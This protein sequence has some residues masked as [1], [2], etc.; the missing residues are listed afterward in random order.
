MIKF[1]GI[2]AATAMLC[3]C[4]VQA[5]GPS[6]SPPQRLSADA[7]SAGPHHP[8]R[9]VYVAG[10]SSVAGYSF[11]NASNKPPVCTVDLAN[12][13]S[14]LEDVAVDRLG[15]LMVPANDD[16]NS[17]EI[18]SGPTLC[19]RFLGAVSQE[20][21]RAVDAASLDAATGKIIVAASQDSSSS[22]GEVEVCS[23]V[24]GCAGLIGGYPVFAAVAVAMDPTGDCWASMGSYAEPVYSL[25]YFKECAGQGMRTWGWLNTGWGGLDV[26]RA[27]NLLSISDNGQAGSE[28]FVYK[29]CKPICQNIGGPF[30][31]RHGPMYGHLNHDG[32]L[33]ATVGQKHVDVYAYGTTTL[34]HEYSFDKDLPGSSGV[35]FS[36]G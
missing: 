33:F 31:L 6:F 20:G 16:G 10:T 25:M 18:Y 29:G 8:R 30:T 15:D 14:D 23:L 21:G 17:V 11:D 19:G 5:A 1:M 24:G 22:F 7:S 26:D 3:S 32:T 4:A 2:A 28:L 13:G 12:K 35:A 36:P 34:K 9:G 27:G